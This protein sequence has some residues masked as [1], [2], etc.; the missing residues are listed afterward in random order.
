VSSAGQDLRLRSRAL[1]GAVLT[2]VGGCADPLDTSRQIE[3]YAS[4]GA[5][6]YREA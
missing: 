5:L 1:I 2:L 6:T 4:F 3:P